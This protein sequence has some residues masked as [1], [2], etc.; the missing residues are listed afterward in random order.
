VAG[1]LGSVARAFPRRIL[2]PVN[3]SAPKSAAILLASLALFLSPGANAQ[4][5]SLPAKPSTG[6]PTN[7][8]AELG[9]SMGQGSHFGEI[10]WTDEQFGAFID[11]MR[12]AF[13]G[14]PF[15]MDETGHKLSAEM[16]RRISEIDAGT[17]SPFQGD[18]PLS[19]YSAFGSSVGVGGHFG[20]IGWTEDQFDAFAEG[21][22]SAFKGKPYDVEDS[23][24][25]LAAD[26]SRRISALESAGQPPQE[27]FDPNKLVPFMK[28]ASKR[29]HL[30]L[31]DS[32]LGY[33]ISP[34]RNGI[35]PRQGDTVVISCSAVAADGTTKIPQ[36]SSDRIRSKLDQM[37]PGFR[38]GLQMMT[39][40]S[41]GILVLPPA[42]TFG[43]GQWPEGVQPN[44][45]IVFEVTLLDVISAPAKTPQ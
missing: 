28:D 42:L 8:Y 35:R 38:E 13:A 19:A 9:S 26:M 24:R 12:A 40:G 17:K 36:L 37:F 3:P 21:M 22:R 18:F 20:E 41:H 30:Q 14:K 32:G 2:N 5:S 43:H 31:S 29:Y 39:V 11:G 33:N 45:P 7:A 16:S 34:G 15:E 23:A 1:R 4:S 44:S 25:Q 10:G 6:F 27:P